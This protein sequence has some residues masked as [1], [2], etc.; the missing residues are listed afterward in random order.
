MGEGRREKGLIR[1]TCDIVY[2][3]SVHVQSQYTYTCS[4]ISCALILHCSLRT[5]QPTCSRWSSSG[6]TAPT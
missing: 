4:Y 1:G 5:R 3:Y 6:K 2:T